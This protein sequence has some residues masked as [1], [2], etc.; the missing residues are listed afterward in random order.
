MPHEDICNPENNNVVA[1]LILNEF[2]E[3]VSN[4]D[5]TL[6]NGTATQSSILGNFTLEAAACNEHTLTLSRTDNPANGV[7]ALDMVKIRQHILLLDTLQ[8]PYQL[9]AAD[10]NRFAVDYYI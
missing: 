4:V 1:G 10:V 8:S 3:E 6:S 7:T 2:N 5:L 9:V